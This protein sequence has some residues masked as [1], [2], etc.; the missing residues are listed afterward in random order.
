MGFE[1]LQ[2]RRPHHLSGQPVSV[3]VNLKVKSFLLMFRWDLL[4]SSRCPLP[5]VLSS[6]TT[7]KSHPLDPNPSG[8]CKN[9]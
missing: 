3:S 7:K 2:R 5:L 8:I 6:G 1:Y 4:C 9:W